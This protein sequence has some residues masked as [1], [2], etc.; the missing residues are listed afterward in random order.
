VGNGRKHS[1]DLIRRLSVQIG[2]HH[3]RHF[4]L[5][6]VSQHGIEAFDPAAV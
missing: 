1:R 3:D 5:W 4:V 6:I 2:Q